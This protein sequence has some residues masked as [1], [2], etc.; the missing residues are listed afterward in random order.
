[1]TKK[2]KKARPDRELTDLQASHDIK[3]E[4]LEIVRKERDALRAEVADSRERIRQVV[5]LQSPVAATFMEIAAHVGLGGGVSHPRDVLALVVAATAERDALRKALHACRDTLL[6]TSAANS[7][8]VMCHGGV[9]REI[10][11]L[12]AEALRAADSLLLPHM[13]RGAN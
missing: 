12:R 2:T 10:S 13:E 4:N 8:K 7:G 1:M 5:A 9:M 3:A 11:D 6:A